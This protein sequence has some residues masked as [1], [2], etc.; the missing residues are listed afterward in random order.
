MD[1]SKLPDTLDKVANI[2]S[3]DRLTHQPGYD[4]A[5]YHGDD[6]AAQMITRNIVNSDKGRETIN[7]LRK[8]LDPARPVVFMPIIND[9]VA[10]NLNV[11][12]HAYAHELSK[13]LGG[14]VCTDVVKTG[15]SANTGKT[16]K[17]RVNKVIPFD[18]FPSDKTAQIV[19]VDD[20]YTTGSTIRAPIEYLTENGFDVVAITSLANG[21]FGLGFK[22]QQ[23]TLDK[24][25]KAIKIDSEPINGITE[26]DFQK[27]TDAEIVAVFNTRGDK[28]K[29]FITRYA[30]A[31]IQGSIGPDGSQRQSGQL[32]SETVSSGEIDPSTGISNQDFRF[33]LA[34]M[35]GG[36]I[37]A[38]GKILLP[39]VADGSIKSDV[40]A[41]EYLKKQGITSL[42]LHEIQF[43][44]GEARYQ[45]KQIEARRLKFEY[46]NW[47]ASQH[48]ILSGIDNLGVKIKVDKKFGKQKDFAGAYVDYKNGM[49]S[50]EAAHHLKVDEAD[51][52]EAVR[53][54]KKN[55]LKAQF[56]T[57]RAESSPDAYYAKLA[58]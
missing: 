5:K 15:G 32:G 28:R 2:T 14:T 13:I 31:E 12:P 23:S 9:E 48:P 54:V 4:A 18:G 22:I 41:G 53:G 58:C 3:S 11:L 6:R 30:A 33:S 10:G 19:M 38:L 39:G 1:M 21:R 47:L 50:D 29:T 51:L 56:K 57:W 36:D 27:F 45:L 42:E 7:E 8:K 37:E 40:D 26:N 17:E 46:N 20:V 43:A 35:P 16:V 34:S 44:Y 49:P 52:V 24:L 55:D 25:K